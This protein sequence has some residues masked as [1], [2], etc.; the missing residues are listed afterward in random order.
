MSTKRTSFRIRK[1]DYIED[2]T[3]AILVKIGELGYWPTEQV[4]D[5][6]EEVVEAAIAG[7]MFGWD[8]KA[9]QPAIEWSNKQ[10]FSTYDAVME[11]GIWLEDK[12]HGLLSR[13]GTEPEESVWLCHVCCK[14]VD[15]DEEYHGDNCGEEEDY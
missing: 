9:A 8:C 6:P 1:P 15:G 4:E 12:H 5:L 2:D 13:Y 14:I 3:P 7:S 10:D 11:N